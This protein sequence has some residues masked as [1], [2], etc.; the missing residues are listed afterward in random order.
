MIDREPNTDREIA[1]TIGP[2]DF[3]DAPRC[4]F[5]NTSYGMLA[6]V[7][8]KRTRELKDICVRSD[9]SPLIYADSLPHGLLNSETDKAARRGQ[10]AAPAVA[11]HIGRI[12]SHRRMIDRVRIVIQSGLKAS[13]F[14]NAADIIDRHCSARSLRCIKLPFFHGPNTAEIQCSLTGDDRESLMQVWRQFVR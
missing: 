3:R 8:D 11:D 13:H 6:R 10:I 7:I 12:F 4:G 1:N 2:Y 14:R 9:G 5:W